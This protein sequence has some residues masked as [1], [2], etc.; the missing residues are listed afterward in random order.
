M[1]RIGRKSKRSGLNRT[2]AGA[3]DGWVPMII[4][5]RL[6]RQRDCK[7]TRSPSLLAERV[8][9]GQRDYK[10]SGS[11]SVCVER[12]SFRLFLMATE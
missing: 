3:I 6:S 8:R 5:D 7:A 12:N 4:A 10:T 1:V 2:N 11:G 9:L